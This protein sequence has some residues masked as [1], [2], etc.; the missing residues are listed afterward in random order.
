VRT[1]AKALPPGAAVLDLGCGHGVPISQALIEDGFEAYR[2]ETSERMTAAFRER[3]PQQC[4][5]RIWCIS[6]S[7]P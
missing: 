5:G 1:W 3:F 2:I 4:G 7:F 6:G